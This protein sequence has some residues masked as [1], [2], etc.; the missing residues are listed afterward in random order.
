MPKYSPGD[1]VKC[2][3]GGGQTAY[4]VNFY[5][6]TSAIVLESALRMTR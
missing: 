6:G 3:I 2:T 5:D 1:R 4:K